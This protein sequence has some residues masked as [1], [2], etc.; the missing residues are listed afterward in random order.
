M[1][2]FKKNTKGIC[3]ECH[4]VI[5]DINDNFCTNCG[6]KISGLK[7]IKARTE[8]ENREK[9]EKQN[10]RQAEHEAKAQQH[11]QDFKESMQGLKSLK[12]DLGKNKNK[13][14]PKP[15]TNETEKRVNEN[16][17][18]EEN[19]NAYLEG[20][21]RKEAEQKAEELKRKIG[22]EE[23]ISNM[24]I[25]GL[26]I[27]KDINEIYKEDM[28]QKIDDVIIEKYGTDEEKIKMNKRKEKERIE[29]EEQKRLDELERQEY[30]RKTELSNKIVDNNLKAQ[31]LEEQGRI[32]EAQALL[33]ENMRLGADTPFTFTLLASI[34]HS[35]K[36]FEKERDT[37]QTFIDQLNDD[38]RVRD[39]YKIDFVER[40][41]NVESYL[42][43][44][45]WK[46]DC[47]P[48]DS[49]ANYYKIKEAKTL[50]NSDEREK[51]I[52]MLEDIMEKGT[53]NNT[54]YNTLFQTYKKDKKFDDAIRVC[55][56]AIEVLGFYSNDRKN[57]WNINLEKVTAQKEKAD[58]K[59]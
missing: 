32:N 17:S 3:P 38:P 23:I 37:L 41:E 21:S 42:N 35:K 47:L 5:E 56:K 14:K 19:I 36:E 33:E 18:F 34:Y 50:L 48:S 15:I 53:Y 57:R 31:D 20:L 12:F 58:K 45:K 30:L 29:M 28:Y 13:E 7:A 4:S 59:K 49:K 26:D 51:G 44:G 27:S 25:M 40:L 46:Y 6:W 8:L 16:M 55:N 52:L 10:I 22:E 43:T 11:K 2:F 39:S 1:R 9:R 24:N 54:V